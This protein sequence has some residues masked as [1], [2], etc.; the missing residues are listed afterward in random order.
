MRNALLA[1]SES[2]SS[3]SNE[4]LRQICVV[5]IQFSSHLTISKKKNVQVKSLLLRKNL[6]LLQLHHLLKEPAAMVPKLLEAAES[7]PDK[8]VDTDLLYCRLSNGLSEF[9]ESAWNDV[10]SIINER[11]AAEILDDANLFTI[12]KDRRYTCRSSIF[13]I[14]W[15]KVAENLHAHLATETWQPETI[16]RLCS[17]YCVTK[18]PTGNR[19]HRSIRF[20]RILRELILLD[21]NQGL[22]RWKP[23]SISLYSEFMVSCA[24]G[25]IATLPNYFVERIEQMQSQ[26]RTKDIGRISKGLRSRQYSDDK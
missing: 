26:F 4:Q 14:F 15:H 21:V 22:S 17:L 5:S 24:D 7:R 18:S 12:L 16:N 11:T 9:S 19:N 13:Q 1:I 8:C 23:S 25:N 6:L 2:I 20:E 3:A 10:A